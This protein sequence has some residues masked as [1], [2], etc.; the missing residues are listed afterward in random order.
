MTYF[1]IFCKRTD[2]QALSYLPGQ[3]VGKATLYSVTID[4]ETLTSLK[5]TMPLTLCLLP[6][7]TTWN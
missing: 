1:M 4:A 5:M 3:L 6:T 7:H 2:I